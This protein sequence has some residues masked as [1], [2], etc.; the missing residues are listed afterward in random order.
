M[1]KSRGGQPTHWAE[2]VHVW[3]WYAEVKRRSGWSDYQLDYEFAWRN[4][5]IQSRSTDH[6]PR[7]FEWIRKKA[8][9][10]RGQD[11]CWRNMVELVNAVEQHPL[12][13]GTKR[14]Y[15][16]DIWDMFQETI[17]RP[18]SVE[19]RI[20]KIL[21]ENNLSRVKPSELSSQG[22]NL[23]KEFD[24]VTLFDKCLLLT[25][26]QLDMLSGIE[27]VWSLHLLSQPTH[28][29]EYRMRIESIA[30]RL[31]DD[32]FASFISDTSEAL[33]FYV[34]AMQSLQQAKLDFS[35]HNFFGYGSL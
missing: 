8:R 30:D 25:L 9:K 29:W 14:L 22:I 26:R 23:L 5:S 1:A 6:R 13:I 19:D 24:E 28:N 4:P 35:Q 2:R 3:C 11:P 15:E 18:E 21:Q 31:L 16:S 32:F 27:L 33:L 7:I 20:D 12:F 34:F 10:P 17:P